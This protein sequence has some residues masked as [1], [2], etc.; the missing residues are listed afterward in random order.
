MRFP[1]SY[2]PGVFSPMAIQM[3]SQLFHVCQFFWGGGLE[4]GAVAPADF[5]LFF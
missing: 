4:V 1:R 5:V 2:G 3:C